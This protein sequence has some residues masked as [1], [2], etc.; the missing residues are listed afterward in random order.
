MV[1]SII[2]KY[3]VL[4]LALKQWVAWGHSRMKNLVGGIKFKERAKKG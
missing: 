4:Q 2:A 1:I 3:L